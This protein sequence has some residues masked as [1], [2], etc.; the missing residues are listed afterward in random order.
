M[1]A[2]QILLSLIVLSVLSFSSALP[3]RTLS[4][5]AEI[6]SDFGY[7]SMALTLDLAS[8]T[9]LL[10]QSP[11]LTIFTPTD[12][13]F[14]H[15]GQPPLNLLQ[16][17]IIPFISLSDPSSPCLLAPRSQLYSLTTLSPSHLAYTP[18]SHSTTSPSL[19]PQF[20]MM[21]R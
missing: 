7:T 1:A 21:G 12:A 8:Q 3:T 15:S 16:F 10:S 2:A 13:A 6:L 11:S 4:N 14:S 20:S 18:E 9:L 5:A 19:F 17:H